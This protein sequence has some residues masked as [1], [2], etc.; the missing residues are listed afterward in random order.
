MIKFFLN[1]YFLLFLALA[2]SFSS[3]RNDD[4]EPI[5]TDDSWHIAIDFGVDD[6][7]LIFDTMLYTNAAGNKYSVQN[8]KFYISGFE[9]TF[10]DGKVYKNA[11][12][13]LVDA[14]TNGNTLFKFNRYPHG[15]YSNIKF[16]VGV[17]GK[18]N[19]IGALPN[20]LA[21]TEMAW[22][23]VMGG[24]YHFIKFEGNFL[25][26]ASTYGY[27]MHL[28]N[29]KNIVRIDLNKEVLFTDA[30]DTLRLHM[31][32]NEWFRNPEVFDFNM[33]GNYSM[34]N[35]AAMRKLAKNGADV[36]TIK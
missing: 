34:G 26:S 14:R 31:N 30:S 6:E 27:A 4:G 7:P 13:I 19:K 2:I 36:F 10:M 23:D 29:S 18:Y 22:P 24:G 35:T 21:N 9:A 28:G 12:V 3:C 15:R 16:N 17:S 25:D 8:L 5:E 32:L 11:D 1:I 20:T 33:D